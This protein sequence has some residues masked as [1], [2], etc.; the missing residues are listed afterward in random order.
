MSTHK[1]TSVLKYLLYLLHIEKSNQESFH[2]DQRIG[3]PLASE[4]PYTYCK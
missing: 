1:C 2:A 4:L 3:P